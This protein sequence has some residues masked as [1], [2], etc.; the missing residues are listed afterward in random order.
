MVVVLT[1]T[2]NNGLRFRQHISKINGYE[3]ITDVGIVPQ[4]N[5]SVF[6][7]PSGGKE[8]FILR[9]V[10]GNKEYLPDFK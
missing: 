10:D 9:F 1:N 6:F 5:S 8:V 2:N 3:V 7:L 4:G